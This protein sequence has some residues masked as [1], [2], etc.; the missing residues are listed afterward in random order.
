MGSIHEKRGQKSRA[1]VALSLH[2]DLELVI[3]VF[4]CSKRNFS[5]NRKKSST[6]SI[7]PLTYTI[8]T[9]QVHFH[10]YDEEKFCVFLNI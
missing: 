1:T 5:L 9:I 2:M 4:P 3:G 10:A 7:I 6:L 8:K